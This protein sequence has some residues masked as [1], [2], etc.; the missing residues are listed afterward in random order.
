MP[1]QANL[2]GRW[3]YP[4]FDKGDSFRSWLLSLLCHKAGDFQS[5]QFTEDTVIRIERHANDGPGKYRVHVKE[6]PI[7]SLP[8]CTDLIRAS[9][10]TSDFM[11]D[12]E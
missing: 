5:A 2:R 3:A 1:L 4:H 8:G 10:F 12:N 6:L 11:G 7:A 9:T